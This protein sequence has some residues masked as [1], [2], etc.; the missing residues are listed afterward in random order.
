V[1]ETHDAIR[2]VRDLRLSLAQGRAPLGLLLSAGCAVAVKDG[3]EPLIPDIAGMTAKLE[4][5]VGSGVAKDAFAKLTECLDEDGATDANVEKWL[6]QVRAMRE[7]A[8]SGEVRGLSTSELE[9]LE[10]AITDGIVELADKSLPNSST[11][12][13]NVAAWAG[14]ME[15]D[16]P[17]EIFTT[18]YD[19]LLEEAFEGHRSAYFDGFVGAREPF[20]DNASV[21]YADES[22]LPPR[23]TR[24]WKLHG[25][26]NWY[27]AEEGTVT[28]SQRDLGTR[29]LI[30][31]SHLKYD[32][33]RQMPFLALLDR[34]RAFLGQ[35]GARLV[36]C[37]YSF[38]DNHINAT[39]R[40]GLQAN[41]TSSLIGLLYG[42]LDGYEAASKLARE[43]ANV[44]V[45]AAD[46]AVIGTQC[47]DWACDDT[48][49][50]GNERGVRT[51]AAGGCEVVLGDFV[52]FG[53]L[54]TSLLNRPTSGA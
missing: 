10:K 23:F 32:E 54:L 5:T 2:H 18:N 52:E 30:H 37:G 16:A 34:L 51:G 43:Q 20:F 38:R 13:H 41:P 40:D 3:G 45:Y 8:G 19:L 9:A 46:A 4:E 21:S 35:R 14:A 15:R 44:A 42:E 11:P 36:T 49:S 29:R 24:L 26:M 12:F 1:A 25:S 27:E 31:P 48:G 28:R 53:A 22:P 39:L 7:V 50:S 47:A 33:S 17:V 6:S